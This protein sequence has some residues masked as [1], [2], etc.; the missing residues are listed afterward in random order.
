M[1]YN[2]AVPNSANAWASDLTAMAENFSRVM[3]HVLGDVLITGVVETY[4]WDGANER[5]SGVTLSGGATGSAAYTYTGDDL[6][7]IVWSG[8]SFGSETLTI[9]F[10]YSS[11]R[12][13]TVTKTIS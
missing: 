5:Y 10:V 9:D 2:S 13:T 3:K 7:K 11:G 12:L 6:T 1:A 8:G 4:A